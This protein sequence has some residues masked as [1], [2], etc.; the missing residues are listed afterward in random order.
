[1]AKHEIDEAVGMYGG[2]TC[3]LPQRL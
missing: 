2:L 1:L 3:D